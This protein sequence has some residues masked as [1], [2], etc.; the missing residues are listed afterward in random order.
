M[1]TMTQTNL[2]ID[3]GSPDAASS[4]HVLPLTFLLSFAI[5]ILFLHEE[6]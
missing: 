2:P 5:G 3:P 1:L 6:Y 4:L